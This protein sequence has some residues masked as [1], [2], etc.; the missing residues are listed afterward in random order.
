MIFSTSSYFFAVLIFLNIARTS[1]CPTPAASFA[2]TSSNFF[3]EITLN[4][5]TLICFL[6]IWPLSCVRRISRP[7]LAA[8]S[9]ITPQFSYATDSNRRVPHFFCA[10]CRKGAGLALTHTPLQDN[11]FAFTLLV[12][13]VNRNCFVA[14]MKN[15]YS[16]QV[17]E[18]KNS[19]IVIRKKRHYLSWNHTG[20][21]R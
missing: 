19:Y 13:S 10:S 17:P 16:S 11:A 3:E 15:H 4:L 1:G 9:H 7:V 18:K 8:F 21:L 12:D 14:G 20:L 6:A 5:C 2:T